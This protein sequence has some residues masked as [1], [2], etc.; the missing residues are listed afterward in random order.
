MNASDLATAVA[1]ATGESRRTIQARGFSLADP[2]RT[3]FDPEPYGG[4]GYLDWDEVDERR[5]S[6]TVVRQA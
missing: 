2:L 6:A 3:D 1:A 5:R 4:S